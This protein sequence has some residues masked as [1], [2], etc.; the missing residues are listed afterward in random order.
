[1]FFFAA[2][3]GM[4]G[5]ARQAGKAWSIATVI[6]FLVM[7]IMAFIQRGITGL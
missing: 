5:V 2:T 4:I 3:G 6:V 7:A 1:M